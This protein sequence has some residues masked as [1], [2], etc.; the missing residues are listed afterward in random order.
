MI[1]HAYSGDTKGEVVLQVLRRGDTL[2]FRLID[3]A[4]PVDA[5]KIEPRKLDDVRPGGLGV[6]IMRQIMDAVFR[7]REASVADVQRQLPDDVAYDAIRV[8][9][10]ILERK[11]SSYT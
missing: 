9:L 11:A 8:T 2:V 4:P 10:G 5:R 6:H 3:F 7:L 1:R